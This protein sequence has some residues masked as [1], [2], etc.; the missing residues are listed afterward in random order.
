MGQ[1]QLSSVLSCVRNLA[2]AHQAEA[3]SDQQ[4]LHRFAS[5]NDSAAFRT[6]VERYGRRV[7]SVCRHVLQH[8]QDAED[9]F[10]ATFLV[11]ARK[12]RAIRRQQALASWLHGVAYRIAMKAKRDAARRR[13]HEPR[14]EI[15]PSTD[16]PTELSWREVQAILD[17]EIQHLPERE[18]AA[19]VLCCLEGLSRAEAAQQLHLKEGTLSSRLASARQRL[20]KRLAIRGVTLAAVLAGASLAPTPVSAALVCSTVQAAG[21][22]AAGSAAA[23]ALSAPA[24]DLARGVLKAMFVSKV[25][26]ACSLVM[27]LGILSAGTGYTVRAGFGVGVASGEDTGA[28]AVDTP[29]PGVF[30]DVTAE[31]GIAFTYR[32]GE[33]AGH[34]TL[35]ESLGG[36]VAVLD[37]DGDGLVDIFFT[38]G[39]YFTGPDRK[40]I[41]SHPCKLYKNLGDGRFQ[42][43]TRE[44]GLDIIDFYTHGVAV[45]D[46]DCDGWPDLLVTGWDH[47][48]LFHNESDGRG[49]RRF[50]DVSA[51]AGLPTGLWTTSAA[52]ADL[53]G[54]GFPDLYVCQFVDWSSD[55]PPGSVSARDT[56]RKF[57]GL[58]HKLYRNNGDGTFTDVSG[59]A[60]LKEG[61][62]GASK[63]LGVVIADLDGDGRPD[64]YVANDTTDNFLYRNECRRGRFRFVEI[65][66]Q[67]GVARDDRGVPLG[68]KGVAVGDFDGSGL[69]SLLVAGHENEGPA[70]Y[71]NRR[72]AGLLVFQFGTIRAG[73]ATTGRSHAGWGAAFLDYD[74]DGDL[75]LFIA[76]GQTLPPPAGSAAR[77]QKPVLLRNIGQGKF[78]DVTTQAG[79]YFRQE[80]NARGVAFVDFDNDGRLDLIIS[81]LGEPVVILRNQAAERE[82]HWIGFDLVGQ[83]RRDVT[84]ATVI[85]ETDARTQTSFSHSGGSYASSSDRRHLFGLGKTEKVK[86]IR[87]RWPGGQEQQWDGLAVDRYWR[88]TEG[89]G[90]EEMPRGR[91]RGAPEKN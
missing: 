39:G 16:A 20:Q 87:V 70:L 25:Q 14:A 67:A 86:R 52:F 76:N 9:A 65:G 17:E 37:Y 91:A 35:L 24:I 47:L 53:D 45:V 48:A 78:V 7:F 77:G 5:D 79:V 18:R 58:P 66:L 71:R 22:Y 3:V 44:A 72:H 28:T 50:V 12:A 41:R 36:G 46:Y 2:A 42:D 30:R 40:R 23:G 73:I 85:V 74:C 10:Q 75:D 4:L 15:A 88:L 82:H 33:E 55:D 32:N 26:T 56:S 49:G 13:S 60:G 19:F 43:V 57:R 27:A 51:R 81:H 54:D 21:L 31:S 6:L 69:P 59:E 84:G 68:S 11:L 34:D 90:A 89:E 38:G 63:G 83:K 1:A 80:H 61:G 64:I 8:T 62:L 29:A